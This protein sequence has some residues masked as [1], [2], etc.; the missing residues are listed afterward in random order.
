M[1]QL[2]VEYVDTPLWHAL[3]HTL[4]ELQATGEVRVETA[5][6]YVIAYLCQELAAKGV[7]DS[8]ALVPGRP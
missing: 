6:E 3:E 5:V 2:H 7:I 8:S 1:G 4:T